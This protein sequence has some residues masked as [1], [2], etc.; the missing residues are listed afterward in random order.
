MKT[1]SA[2]VAASLSLMMSVGVSGAAAAAEPGLSAVPT[3]RIERE[4]GAVRNLAL[5]TGQNRL[6][7][8]TE[9][10]GRVSVADPRIADL[11]VI[12]PVQLLL[13]SRGVGTTDL[14]LW[15]K[16]DEPLV[17]ALQVTRNL[18]RLKTQLADLFPRRKSPSRRPAIWWF[19]PARSPT[20]A[21]PSERPRSPSFTPRRWPT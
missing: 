5:E 10:I 19:F 12:T 4:V 20:C 16:H 18:D 17:L 11:K 9:P 8:L 3:I 1:R 15:N 2:V 7:I 13:T 6:L 14:T 21:F